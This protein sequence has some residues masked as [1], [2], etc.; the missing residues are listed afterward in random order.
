MTDAG[1]RRCRRCALIALLLTAAS[2][3]TT[4]PSSGQPVPSRT[5]ILPI[6]S[7]TLT[8]VEFL[9]GVTAGP[10]ARIAGDLRGPRANVRTPA[11]I[12][13][14]GLDGALPPPRP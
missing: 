13:P 10:A 5:E 1:Y 6:D 4:G 3:L 9:T 2:A 8:E 11:V 7:V 12:V 14:D